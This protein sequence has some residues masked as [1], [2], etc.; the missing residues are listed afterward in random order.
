M[1][2]GDLF[3]PD[4]DDTEDLLMAATYRALCEHGYADL[5]IERIGAEFEKSNSLLY[6]HY[7]GKDDLLVGFL[8]YVL[9]RFEADV[10]SERTGDPWADMLDLLDHGLAPG[11]EAERREFVSAMIEL[12][13]QAAHDPAYREA[14][15]RHDRFFRERLASDIREGIESGDFR[16]V[17]ADRVARL[18]HTMFTG[19]MTRR[20]T[21]D[22]DDGVS[23]LEGVREEFEAML[24]ARLLPE[25]E[26]E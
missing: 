6:H 1:S 7:D 26:D 17:D 8:E 11:I 10:P 3:D 22:S 14:F 18:V 24:A 13:A 4:S 16:D 20:V 25:G 21:A 9:D 15:T 12:R 2:P 5:T 23:P 19:A